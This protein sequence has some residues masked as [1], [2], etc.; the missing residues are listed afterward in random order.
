MRETG[1]ATS[2]DNADSEDGAVTGTTEAPAASKL[3]PTE[4][5]RAS[6]ARAPNPTTEK[7]QASRALVTARWATLSALGLITLVQSLVPEL[8][9]RQNG[10][11][12]PALGLIGLG[13]LVNLAA[14]RGSQA[15][16]P[17]AAALQLVLDVAGLTA[18]LAISGAAANPFTMLYFVP[19]GLATLLPRR[20]TWAVAAAALAGFALLLGITA[21]DAT[22]QGHFLHHLVGMWLGLAISGGT[23]TFFVHRLAGALAKQTRE[24]ERTRRQAVEAHH[25][26][27]LGALAAGAAHELGTP[28]GTIQLLTAELGA[29]SEAEREEAL[30]SIRRELQRCKEIIHDMAAPEISAEHLARARSW[31]LCTLELSD[32]RRPSPAEPLGSVNAIGQGVQLRMGGGATHETTQPRRI[33]QRMVEELVNNALCA[34][35]KTAIGPRVEVAVDASAGW[36]TVTVT[37]NGPG[38]EASLRPSIFD[39]FFTTKIEGRGLGLYL[40]RAHM[41]QLGGSIEVAEAEPCGARFTLSFP[42]RAPAVGESRA[43]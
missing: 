32:A 8:L 34:C 13:A 10:G 27:S 19:I 42:L 7:A 43:P 3:P 41:H 2:L 25:L 37:D 23:I 40:A 33:V 26:G 9:G 15:W 1:C 39:A 29:M 14:A 30:D 12:L 18:F 36:A 20:L 28:L 35:S 21:L 5:T 4:S 24:L 17:R 22:L 11:P 16:S 6:V 31:K 38:I